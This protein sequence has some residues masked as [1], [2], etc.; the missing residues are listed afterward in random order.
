M[1]EGRKPSA[2]ARRFNT[3]VIIFLLTELKNPCI[4]KVQKGDGRTMRTIWFDMDGTIAN[5]YAVD[6]W[7]EKLRNYDPT[8]YVEAEVM[9]N[10]SQLAR[11]LNQLKVM[12]YKLG[13]ISWLSKCP[14][15]EYD[16]AVGAAKVWWLEKHLPSVSWDEI[17]IVPNGMPKE[18]FKQ[19]DDDILFDDEAKNR[20]NWGGDAYEPEM[21]IKVLKA[22]LGKEW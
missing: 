6:N 16:K 9:L 14:T 4:I 21:I 20:E 3:F 15:A 10:M 18:W 22:L 12:G 5:L 2:P 7:L 13:V 11:L 1:T 8:P 17:K 19:S